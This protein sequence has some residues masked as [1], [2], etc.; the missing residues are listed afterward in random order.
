MHPDTAPFFAGS[1]IC[2]PRYFVGYR[3]QLDTITVRAVSAQPTS[4]NIVGEKRIGKSSM[5]YHFCQT[6]EQKIESRGRNSRNYL[7]VYLSLQQNKCCRKS[8]FYE[9]VAEAL[10]KKLKKKLSLVD[11]NR[12]RNRQLIKKLQSKTWNAE[13]FLQII[14]NFKEVEILPIICLDKI[15]TLFQYPEE[16][17]NGFYDNLRSLMDRSALMLVIASYQKLEVYSNQHKLTSS[18]FNLGQTEI[19]EGFNEQETQ[20]LVRLPQTNIPSIQS[21]LNAQE[22]QL[23]LSWGNRNPYLLQL[24]SLCL[25]D[26]QQRNQDHDWAKRKFNERKVKISNTKRD[27]ESIR[28]V[29]GQKLQIL[30]Q[31]PANLIYFARK[32]GDSVGAIIATGIGL[33]FILLCILAINGSIPWVRIPKQLGQFLCSTLSSVLGEFCEDESIQ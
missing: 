18:F 16:F 17:N 32:I 6:Y 22:Q 27:L 29:S 25:W 28:K 9:V 19:L 1:M 23:A 3:E 5:L 31:S 11:R 26:A 33:T 20:G 14:L 4:I 30:I 7:A 13:N 15:E 24:A 12:P 8:G 10:Y 21:V 2:D